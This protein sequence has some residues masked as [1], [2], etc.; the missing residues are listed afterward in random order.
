LRNAPGHGARQTEEFGWFSL[1]VFTGSEENPE[2][3]VKILDGRSVT[4][5]FWVFHAG[6]T[7]LGYVLSV[8]D[9]MTG[10]ARNYRKE[11]GTACGGF[12]TSHF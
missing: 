11:A 1:P 9:T 12:E 2:V 10:E 3:F 5:H 6:L 4:G 7:D 8:T